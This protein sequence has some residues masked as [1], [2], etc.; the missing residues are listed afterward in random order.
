MGNPGETGSKQSCDVCTSYDVISKSFDINLQKTG[1]IL[2][3]AAV[4]LFSLLIYLFS[5]HEKIMRLGPIVWAVLGI[6]IFTLLICCSVGLLSLCKNKISYEEYTIGASEGDSE[7]RILEVKTYEKISLN[8]IS[9]GD[10]REIEH[11]VKKVRDLN[12]DAV[13]KLRY[14]YVT[15]W[16]SIII[17]IVAVFPIFLINL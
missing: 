4:I 15:L 12:E 10:T 9:L 14:M 17:V 16:F 8:K 6:D 11:L 1:I 5:Y 13:K 7:N 2:G 3:F